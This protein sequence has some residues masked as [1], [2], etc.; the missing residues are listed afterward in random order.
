MSKALSIKDVNISNIVI[1]MA[2]SLNIAYEKKENQY[3]LTI[4]KTMGSGYV[5]C[6][7]FDN[8]IGVVEAEYLLKKE[9]IINIE[10]GTV[11]PLKII[12]NKQHPIYHK[13]ESKNEATKVD[14]FESLMVASTPN[15][16]HTF[17]IPPKHPVHIISLEI[18]RKLF[19]EKIESFIPN[20]NDILL[21]LFRDVNGVNPFFYKNFY[22][23]ATSELIVEFT[24]SDLQGFMKSV[25]LEGK[26]Y[27][28]LVAHLQQYIDDLNTPEKRKILR[29][30]TIEKLKKAVKIIETEIDLIDSINK[31]AKRV[32]LNQNT[33]QEGFKHLYKSSVKE[34]I[35]NYRLEKGKELLESSDLNITEICYKIGISSRSYFSKTF[36][37]RYGLTPKIYQHRARKTK[38]A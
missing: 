10:P 3:A 36:K 26:A 21:E 11:H 38:S 37:E 24:D 28:I 4:P 2:E 8:G 30:A 33:L 19:E 12:F 20:M 34:Y 22:S 9:L 23:L 27:E 16:N 15:D 35:K 17:T 7:V 1:D 29:K 31:L 18:N 32:G 25:F 13:F 6:Y 5:K 14:E